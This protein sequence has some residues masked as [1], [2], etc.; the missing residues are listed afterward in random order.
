MLALSRHRPCYTAG[1][2]L[3]SGLTYSQWLALSGCLL[4]GLSMASGY[5]KRL[6][7]S[8]SSVYLA[9]GFVLGPRVLG[10]V[11]LRMAGGSSCST[12]DRAS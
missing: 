11:E 2:T 1:L 6:P 8:S 10:W 7:I 5:V 3:F 12:A 9:V 4:L